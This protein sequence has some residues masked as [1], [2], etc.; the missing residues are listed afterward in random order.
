M[1]ADTGGTGGRG[2]TARVRGT[3]GGG[4]GP[5]GWRTRPAAWGPRLCAGRAAVIGCGPIG[6]LWIR[7]L[8]AG[9]ASWGLAAEPLAHRREAAARLGAD[10]VAGSAAGLG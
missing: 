3:A 2:D 7:V 4:R 1:P 6:V 10:Q 9:G 8:R 5:R